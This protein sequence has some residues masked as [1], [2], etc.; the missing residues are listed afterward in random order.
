MGG[1]GMYE[2]LNCFEEA[3]KHFG[4]R[5]E[6]ITAMEMAKK[7]SPEDAYRMIKDELKEVKACRKKFN[8]N[9]SCN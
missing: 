5:V 7:I 6:M 8:K 2:S 4:T 3:L 1:Y 9:Q